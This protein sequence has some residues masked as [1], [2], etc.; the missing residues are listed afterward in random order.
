MYNSLQSLFKYDHESKIVATSLFTCTYLL[1]ISTL[2]YKRW[3]DLE[4]D[5]IIPI[6][7]C[8]EDAH[9]I[10]NN[11]GYIEFP[12]LATKAL[13]FGFFKT[14]SIPSI[15]KILNSTS[16]LTKHCGDR[17]DDTHLLISEFIE[18][19]PNSGR[20][21]LALKRLNFL[22]SNYNITNIDYIY[23]LS[24]FIVVPIHFITKY[25]YRNLHPK[26]ILASYIVWK[27]IGIKMGIKDI[28]N[29][30][31]EIETYMFT[32]ESKYMKYHIDNNTLGNATIE[33]F[34]SDIPHCLK[35][36]LDPVG[37]VF[38]TSICG[39]QLNIAMGFKQPSKILEWFCCTCIKSLGWFTRFCTLPRD[40]TDPGV[41]VHRTPG[42]DETDQSSSDFILNKMRIPRYFPYSCCRNRNKDINST[43]KTSN[44]DSNDGYIVETLGPLKYSA[45]KTLGY[46]FK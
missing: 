5:D 41:Y 20:A 38:I 44:T 23:V 16:Q 22:H 19:D 11:L 12:F 17:Y 21:H 35:W 8:V 15:S 46:L 14:Y 2:R 28:P 9:E 18:Q 33:L 10:Y 39:I 29:S 40:A 3:Y 27:D 7:T 32:Y 24:V 36:C 1:Y 26:E 4:N 42:S 13:E 6:P 25:G 37:K 31:I 43:S 34:L 45:A 30:Y